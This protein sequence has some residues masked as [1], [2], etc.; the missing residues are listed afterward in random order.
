MV[1][2]SI[3]LDNDFVDWNKEIEDTGKLPEVISDRVLV[4]EI[5]AHR[6]KHGNNFFLKLRPSLN[7]SLGDRSTCGFTEFGF[8]R[9]GVAVVI[10]FHSCFANFLSGLSP[11]DAT[12]LG[13]I[14]RLLNDPLAFSKS[15][16]SVMTASGA[17]LRA[18]LTLDMRNA[19]CELTPASSANKFDAVFTIICPELVGTITGTSSLSS[20]FQTYDISLVDDATNGTFSFNLHKFSIPY[21]NR[22]SG[23]FMGRK[24]DCDVP[25][26]E[27]WEECLRVLK[28][29]GHMLCFAGTRT[30][31][32]MAV[33]IEDAGFEI[34]DMIMW[35]FGSG[36]PKSMNIAK[37]IDK[38]KKGHPQGGPD[39]TS[40]N[41]GKF[42]TG[43]S[44][45]SPFG[46]HHGAGPGQ[47]MKEQGVKDDRELCE[48]AQKW[49]GWGTGLKPAME[50]IT[51]CRKPLE[52]KTIAA[53]VLK[54][55]TGG[56]N[57]DDCRIGTSKDIPASPS[58]T[59]GRS[60]SGSVDGNLRKE[61]GEEGGHNPNVG[62]W[63]ANIIHDHSEEVMK[64][65]PVTKSGKDNKRKK[66]HQTGSMSG[67][68]G[69]T[70]KEEISYGDEG[71]AARFFY[72]AKASRREREQDNKHP[73]VKPLA[74]MEYLVKLVTPPNGIVLD[75][76][77]GSGTTG[78]VC[79]KLGFRFVGIEREPEY[80]E[81]AEKRIENHDV[82]RGKPRGFPSSTIPPYLP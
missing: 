3:D 53:N 21:I 26:I 24:W 62:R 55:G 45:N 70:G 22:K 27:I 31:H 7:S 64:Q 43:C 56:L 77:M 39:P 82:P 38:A 72:C 63:P 51:I 42:K 61:T 67:T 11:S 41:A 48:E 37:S 80:F 71:S 79:K 5:N 20:M 58:R 75:P 47:F 1:E 10:P 8:G 9:L 12:G 18:I 59:K 4:D 36:F 2:G 54:H 65:F 81:L 34:K 46:R 40:P 33:N 29:G 78:M 69:M 44:E 76:F 6:L 28:P 32:R 49:D 74:L 52:E 30:Q 66:P 57:I 23:G 73:A 68:L 13:D 16:S 60:L 25:P 17:E 19:T 15:P 35:C 50:P 14:V